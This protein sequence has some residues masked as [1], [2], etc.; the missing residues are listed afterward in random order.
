M[1]WIVV[2][3]IRLKIVLADI[4]T[5]LKVVDFTRPHTEI[6]LAALA[7]DKIGSGCRDEIIDPVLDLNLDEWTLS[8]IH[9]VA[10]LAFRCLAFHSDMRPTM[11]EV[12]DELEQI[13]L[14]G[15]IPNM[16]LDSPISSLRSSD[17]GSERSASVKKTLAGSKR[18]VTSQAT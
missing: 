2:E 15:W 14:I 16:S 18:L 7:V 1:I 10:D 11:T 4:I 17:Q 12:A 6:N 5:G 13:R 3:N 8:S 9:S